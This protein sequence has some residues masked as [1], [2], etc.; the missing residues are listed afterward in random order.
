MRSRHDVSWLS[1]TAAIAAGVVMSALFVH[2]RDVSR[3]RHQRGQDDHRCSTTKVETATISNMRLVRDVLCYW[4]GQASPDVNQKNL[5]MVQ[6][7]KRQKIVDREIY[8]KFGSLLLDLTLNSSN[9][10]RWDEW[11]N[12]DDM[13]GYAGK[14][15][16][17]VVLDQ[18]SRHI[19]R[20]CKQPGFLDREFSLRLPEQKRMDELALEAAELFVK[21]HCREMQTGMITLPMCIFALMPFRH[22]SKLESVQFV[23]DNVESCLAP[24]LGQT[25]AMIRRFRKATNRRLAVLQDDERRSGSTTSGGAPEYIANA[26][27]T[28]EDILETLSFEA[29]L[30]QMKDHPVHNTIC[31]FLAERGILPNNKRMRQCQTDHPS[32]LIISLSGGVDSMVAAFVLAELVR[33]HGYDGSFKVVAVHIDYANRPESGAEASFV[34][35]WCQKHGID[36]YCRRIDEVTRGITARDEYEAMSRDVR[37]SFYRKI[38]HLYQDPHNPTEA[39]GVV[40]GHHRGDLRENVLSNAHKGCGPLDL[41]GMT[42]VSKANGVTLL[43]PLLSLEKDEIFHFA[44]TFGVP[45]GKVVAHISHSSKT[46]QPLRCFLTIFLCQ[47][48]KDTTPHWSTRGKLRNKLLPLLQEVYGEGCLNN[49]SQ[50]AE[51][52]DHCRALVHSVM[53]RPFFDAIERRPLG[54]KLS[55][56]PFR[57]NDL[58]FWKLVLREALH[59]AGLGMFS[60]KCTEAFL[61]RIQTDQPKQGWLQCRKDYAVYLQENGSVFVLF[62]ESFPWSRKDQY[63]KHTSGMRVSLSQDEPVSIGPWLISLEL[64]SKSTEIN[65]EWDSLLG[66]TAIASMDDFMAGSFSYF[67]PVPPAR[68]AA[69][70][71]VFCNFTK[72][73]RPRAWKGIDTKIQ[74]TLP[75]LCFDGS[76]SKEL[77]TNFTSMLVKISYRLSDVSDQD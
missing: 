64:I 17:I 10:N 49:L 29:D 77:K 12:N 11:C 9:S 28:D 41:S 65:V 33:C 54:I 39:G 67:L 68:E 73:T 2:Y 34:E 36:F 7:P 57:N 47:Y 37:F 16:A 19:L 31:K 23:R 21:T 40:L 72:A 32:A 71:L 38:I 48:F 69:T 59:S 66:Q 70:S 4:F 8:E 6:D 3:N 1:A 13:M 15:A 60:D 50:L 22:A 74:E 5:W 45:V 43:R 30:T 44:H 63:D 61:E 62:P 51:E 56:K 55:T 24:L 25:D 76:S 20:H 18:F 75:L 53:F 58:F 42:P 14:I 27:F 46:T 26:A 52:S 35:R